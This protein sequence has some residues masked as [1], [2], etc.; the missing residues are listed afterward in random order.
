MRIG[1]QNRS[2]AAA[3]MLIPCVMTLAGVAF[4]ADVAP[5]DPPA[6]GPPSANASVADQVNALKE[7]YS[8][9]Q[10]AAS[11]AYVSATGKSDEE[12]SKIYMDR[13]PKPIPYAEK[14][15]ALARQNPKDP[16]AAEALAF[17]VSDLRGN[18][19]AELAKL[20]DEAIESLAR[21]HLEDPGTRAAF[22]MLTYY[23]SPAGDALLKRAAASSNREVRG[24][25]IF[26][27]AESLRRSAEQTGDSGKLAEAKTL[28][29]QVAR[30][31]ADV[32]SFRG[33]LADA[34]KS[35]LFE[36]E[37]LAIGK[38]A[39]EIEGKDAHGNPLKLSDHRGK[40]VVLDFWGDW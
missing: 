15:M 14:A 29:Q 35:N 32:K 1:K 4:A 6:A 26:W 20:R 16:A 3:M 21:D 33:T 38:P 39:P 25:A 8:R 30:E 27:Q 31:F 9:E 7:Q 17:I 11:T 36:M 22:P 40:V 13:A 18:N 28:Y 19:G 24:T 23:P 10:V 34:A 12:R 37:N 5:P 2:R